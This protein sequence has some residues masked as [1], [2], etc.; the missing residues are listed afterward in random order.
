MCVIAYKLWRR[1]QV[2]YLQIHLIYVS[3]SLFCVFFRPIFLRY[4]RL[5]QLSFFLILDKLVSVY[6]IYNTKY[7]MP[8][9]NSFFKYFFIHKYWVFKVLLQVFRIRPQNRVVLFY[10]KSLK[11]VSSIL[12]YSIFYLELLST[13]WTVSCYNFIPDTKIRFL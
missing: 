6:L 1:K 11:Y 3:F 2:I 12:R 9:L 5:H 8:L 4:Y 10:M 7:P 13:V